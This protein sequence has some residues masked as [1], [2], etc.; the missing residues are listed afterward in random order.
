MEA[1]LKLS[2]QSMQPLVDATIYQSIAGSLRYLVNIHPDI[3]FVIGYMS[4]F[5]EEPREDHLAAVK[6][7]VRYVAG[8]S[9]WG[10]WFGRKKRN[11]V[12]LTGFSDADFAGDD[13]ERKST[14]AVIF[15]LVNNPVTWQS[16]KQRVVTQSSCESEYIAVTNA[17][18]QI[19]WLA[20]VLVEVQGSVSS[21]PFLRVDNKSTIALIKNP[22]LHG[23]TCPLLYLHLYALKHLMLHHSNIGSFICYSTYMRSRNRKS[24]RSKLKSKHSLT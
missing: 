11:L 8:T 23:Y 18:C 19:V 20:R 7:I 16:M 2:K 1:H 12:M 13:D 5:L 9:N 22:V 17:M 14:I 10:R 3:A 4:H 6:H 21:T 15:F 24:K